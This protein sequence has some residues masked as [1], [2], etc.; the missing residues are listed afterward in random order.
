MDGRDKAARSSW[1]RI[2]THP[3]GAFERVDEVYMKAHSLRVDYRRDFLSAL[4]PYL[5]TALPS[6]WYCFTASPPCTQ[7]S[8]PRFWSRRHEPRLLPLPRPIRLLGSTTRHRSYI[9]PSSKKKTTTASATTSS[10][11]SSVPN[12]PFARASAIDPPAEFKQLREYMR[13]HRTST[14][15]RTCQPV[16]RFGFGDIL[17]LNA[18]FETED[19]QGKNVGLCDQW[20]ALVR[21]GKCVLEGRILNTPLHG[22]A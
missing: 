3:T 22:R 14:K 16:Q 9:A 15:V 13:T 6:L 21:P 10:T 1:R 8:C 20:C 11:T 12:F 19:V 2:S 18:V 4:S 7:A 17:A 5:P